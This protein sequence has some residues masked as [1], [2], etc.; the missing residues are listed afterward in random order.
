MVIFAA[1]TYVAL[2]MD[3]NISNVMNSYSDEKF[4]YLVQRCFLPPSLLL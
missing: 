2:Y 4:L 1:R 3:A